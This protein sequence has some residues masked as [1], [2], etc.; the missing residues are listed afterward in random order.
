MKVS[1]RSRRRPGLQRLAVRT[2]PRSRSR[3]GGDPTNVFK[4]GLVR[5]ME[6]A[7]D[8]VKS[9]RAFREGR[10]GDLADPPKIQPGAARAHRGVLSIVQSGGAYEGERLTAAR[11]LRD[12]VVPAVRRPVLIA[13]P[14][15]ARADGRA[16]RS[17][18]EP[19]SRPAPPA[20]PRPR[21]PFSFPPKVRRTRR[22]CRTLHRPGAQGREDVRAAHALHPAPQGDGGGPRSRASSSARTRSSSRRLSLWLSPKTLGFPVGLDARGPRRAQ[23]HTRSCSRRARGGAERGESRVAAFSRSGRTRAPARLTRVAR[24]CSVRQPGM[25]FN[26]RSAA[27]GAA[28]RRR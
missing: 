1:R 24:F 10:A 23:R 28:E 6:D 22:T 12:D 16:R 5:P 19:P 20:L 8:Q 15:L 18:D 2:S 4:H 25:V 13:A 21:A 14:S 27:E 26:C 11:T 3:L 9:P 17:G 7:F